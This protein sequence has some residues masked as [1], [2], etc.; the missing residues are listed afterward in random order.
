M[1]STSV[2]SPPSA[3]WR[4]RLNPNPNV[5]FSDP[6]RHHGR[7]DNAPPRLGG[8]ATVPRLW[9]ISELR[10]VVQPA[11]GRS[12]SQERRMWRLSIEVSTLAVSSGNRRFTSAQTCPGRLAPPL[13]R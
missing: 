10:A 9:P 1:V 8:G 2:T 7:L 3:D 13:A 12:G 5:R 11:H 4:A 6:F